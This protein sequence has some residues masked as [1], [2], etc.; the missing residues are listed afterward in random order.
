MKNT[1]N[2]RFLT[3]VAIILVAGII[4]LLAVNDSLGPM[5]QYTIIGAMA[6]FSGAYFQHK[7]K[8]FATPLAILLVSDVVLMQTVYSKFQ[9]GL[10]Y[11]GW[12]WTYGS[13]FIMVA[14]SRWMLRKV[15]VSRFL[16]SAVGTAV[17]HLLVSNFGVWIQGGCTDALTGQPYTM[18]LE[19]LLRCYYM[20]LPYMKNMM[21]GNLVWGTVLFGGFA[22]AQ[23][24]FE[25]LKPAVVK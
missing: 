19:G 15:T 18:D 3:L 13:F 22:L 5:S 21:V 11:D 20:A 25:V 17:I 12:Y 8:S 10:L 2:F 16:G 24:R 23:R 6:L 9:S 14:F 4:R 7:G 1:L